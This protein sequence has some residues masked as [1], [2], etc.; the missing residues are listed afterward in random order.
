MYVYTYAHS[1]I[2]EYTYM[3]TFPTYCS[4]ECN[5]TYV[6]MYVQYVQYVRYVLYVLYIHMSLC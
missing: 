3:C 2:A 5:D 4:C 6:R 1:H